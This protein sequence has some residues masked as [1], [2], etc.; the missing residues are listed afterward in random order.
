MR[1]TINNKLNSPK[2]FYFEDYEVSKFEGKSKKLG[3][4]LSLKRL[5]FV[6]SVFLLVAIIF[7]SKIVYLASLK[8]DSHLSNKSSKVPGLVRQDIRDRNN[9]LLAKNVNVYSGGISPKLINNKGKL[10]INL[11]L[12]FPKIDIKDVEKKIG[13]GNFF[14]LKRRLNELEW[15]KLKV[16]GDKSI[17]LQEKQHR[18]YPQESLFSHVLGQIDDDNFGISGIEKSF[19]AKLT[20]SNGPL[21]LTLDANLQHI[22]REEL[23]DANQVFQTIGSAALLMNINSGEIL[24]LVSLPDFDLNER[25]NIEDPIYLNKITKGVY[26]LG[27]VFKTFTLAAGLESKKINSKTIF[28]D[29]KSKITCA[30]R[31]ISEHDKLPSNL[32]AEQILIRSSNIGA[33]RIAQK[34]G[35]EKYKNFL[36]SLGLF[37]KIEFDL[38]EVGTPLDFRW[39]KCKLA[40]ASFGHGITTT[41]LQLTK[42]Y[43]IIGNGGYKIHPTILF[44]KNN[45]LDQREKVISSKTSDEINSILRKVVFN[46]EGT[47][48]FA[49]VDGYEV[50]G[51]TG[52]AYKS[53]NGEYSKNKIN[54]FVSLFPT[55]RP[56]YILLVMLDEPKPAPNYVY[57]FSNGYKHKGEMRNTAGW[58]TVVVAAKIIEKIGPILAIKNLQASTKY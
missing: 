44:A 32:S 1:K 7:G 26:E 28:K 27:S 45:N 13:V 42:A 33:V 5:S 24:S 11:R 37:K 39:G 52:S 8:N 29:L 49:N 14:Y 15:R 55:G 6:F 46:K 10:L 38:E 41:P 16:L 35:I 56:Q 36:N 54:T 21:I 23:L 4:K 34:V 40:T 22:I 47:A 57:V 2:G 3:V 50:G 19:N 58:N 43:A 30:G 20:K 51:K 25:I 31:S 48:N 17:V 53:V 18:I 9:N 12:I